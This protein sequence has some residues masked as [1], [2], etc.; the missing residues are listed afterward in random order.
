MDYFRNFATSKQ[1][2]I[3]HIVNILKERELSPNAVVK[4]YLTTAA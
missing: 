3:Y 2:A 4:E 1:I